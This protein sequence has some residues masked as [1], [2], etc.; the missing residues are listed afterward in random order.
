MTAKD[1]WPLQPFGPLPGLESLF[2]DHALPADQRS[3][4]WQ[5]HLDEL[6]AEA[7]FLSAFDQPWVQPGPG[8]PEGSDE[9]A[10]EPVFPGAFELEEAGIIDGDNRV[11]AKD[12][13]GVAWRWICEI[14]VF[15]NRARPAG[16]GT[17]V[18]ISDR[19]VLTDA[20]VVYDVYENMQRYMITVIPALIDLE[21]PFGRYTLASKPSRQEYGP[22]ASDRLDWDY[23]L[24]TLGKARSL[25][26][27]ESA[28]RCQ[29]VKRAGHLPKAKRDRAQPRALPRSRT[30]SATSAR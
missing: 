14:D 17:G 4:Q 11:R 15:D 30:L 5:L 24:L 21:E 29:Q 27:E 3:A 8:E 10:Q 18:L 2:L 9:F 13:T 7:A 19:H 22:T 6:E 23:A 26:V 28:H 16:V 20:D 25:P 12:T 1:P